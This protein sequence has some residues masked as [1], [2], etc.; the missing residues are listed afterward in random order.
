MSRCLTRDDV[1]VQELRASLGEVCRAEFNTPMLSGLMY[2]LEK[3]CEDEQEYVLRGC[4]YGRTFDDLCEYV[5]KQYVIQRQS[6]R[7]GEFSALSFGDGVSVATWHGRGLP[8]RCDEVD[9]TPICKNG[10]LICEH[11]LDFIE[12]W[13]RRNKASFRAFLSGL[14]VVE[15]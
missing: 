15:V 5:R 11:Q 1:D 8:Q 13:L 7:D 14:A 9:I 12:L 10:A 6:D 4:R 3:L 2:Q